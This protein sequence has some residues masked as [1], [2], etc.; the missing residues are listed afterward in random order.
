MGVGTK[1]PVCSFCRVIKYNVLTL[2]CF[3]TTL[4]ILLNR[5]F[6]KV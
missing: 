2:G 5:W 1:V 6:D 3:C 4:A